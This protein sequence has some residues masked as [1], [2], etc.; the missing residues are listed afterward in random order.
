MRALSIA[1]FIFII[2][3]GVSA[4]K[5]AFGVGGG[6]LPYNVSAS[7]VEKAS[8]IESVG[9]A[10]YY[11]SIIIYPLKELVKIIGGAALVGS[12]IQSFSPFPLPS[13]LIAGLNVLSSISMVLAVA[14][15]VRGISTRGMD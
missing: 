11:V 4:A 13:V 9:G 15:F 3:L 6:T 7:D 1:I 14:Q 5:E 12:T 10:L 8:R 2:S